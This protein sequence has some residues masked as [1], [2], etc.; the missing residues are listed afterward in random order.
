MEACTRARQWALRT[1]LELVRRPDTGQGRLAGP[2]RGLRGRGG[3]DGLLEVGVGLASRQ[4]AH[5]VLRVDVHLQH[6]RRPAARLVAPIVH[7]QHDGVGGQRP[8]HP[9]VVAPRD[10]VRQLHHVVLDHLGDDHALHDEVRAQLDAFLQVVVRQLVLVQ[11]QLDVGGRHG[12]VE[13]LAEGGRARRQVVRR[14]PAPREDARDAARQTE[15]VAAAEEERRDERHQ[16]PHE[17][18]T[19]VVLA[20]K[21]NGGE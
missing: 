10:V 13:H 19:R 17:V 6:G 2:R 9:H 4:Q 3:A 7:H 1:L 8:D 14:V 18:A 21:R 12:R 16:R 20:G 11:V 5:E 15:P